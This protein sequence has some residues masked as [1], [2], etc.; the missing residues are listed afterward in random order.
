M[1][2][3]LLF[4]PMNIGNMTVKNRIVMAPMH[5]GFG[6]F[7]GTPTEKLMNYY[8]ERAKGGA[9]LIIT[10]ITRVNDFHGASTF[11]QLAMSHDYHIE[12]MRVF[13]ERIHRH[14]AK[15]AVQLHHPGRQNLGLCIGTVPMMIPF[16]N[17]KLIKKTV[18]KIVPKIGPKLLERDLV[19]KVYAPSVCER[20]K[21]ANSKMKAFSIRQIKALEKQFIDAAE[22]LKKAGVDAVELHAAHGYLIQQFLSPYTNKREDEYGGSL[23]NRMRFLTN[24]IA[25]IR[26]RCPDFPVIV[27]LSA[28]ECYEYIGRE[29]TGYTLDEG[30]KMA[31]ALEKAGIDAIDVSSAG[32]DTFNYWLEPV[33]FKT[34]WRKHMA[35]AV[36]NAVKIPVIAANLIRSPEQAEQQIKDGIQDFAAL[37]RPFIADPH[38]A[39]KY[40]EGR[41]DD[42]KRCICCLY[43]IESMQE[44]A[45][46]GTHGECAVNPYLG[47]DGLCYDM[48][49]TGEGKTVAVVGAGPAGLMA[50][51]TL[52]KRGFKVTVFEKEAE[53]GGQINLADKGPDKDKIGWCIKDLVTSV[54]KLG[55]EIRYNAEATAESLAALKP[56]SVFIATGGEAVKPKS[57]DGANLPN[58]FT[59]TDIL[60]GSVELSGKRVLVAGSGMTGLET[61]ELLCKQ[62]NSVTVIEMANTVAPGTWFQHVDDAMQ[63]LNA[64]GTHFLTGKKLVKITESGVIIESVG[65]RQ[66]S[67]I[68]V[69]YVVLALGV[70]P[71]NALYGQIKEKFERVRLIGDAESIGRIADATRNA[72]K[73]ATAL[74]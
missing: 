74:K 69:D 42:V 57:I 30:V 37:G 43:C 17:C 55:G 61:A 16:Q 45:F 29:G 27:R 7:N 63:K 53:A 40:K 35:Q 24:I 70:R 19:P 8:E 28:D 34:G 46:K 73:A 38:C 62:G 49:K 68:A 72:F 25:G 22:R 31:V 3:D 13:A 32:Y 59:T 52:L 71:V 11:T 6:D 33:S 12:P 20:A 14:G 56:Y 10:E 44:N 26:G 9:G 2:Y 66:T 4:S 64:C 41:P 21:F 5:L 1:A 65:S 54:T 15:L 18:F 36:K 51:E 23:E 50:A 39:L 47:R 60:N 58:V 67:E 48:P